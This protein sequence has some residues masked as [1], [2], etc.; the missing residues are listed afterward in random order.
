M[1]KLGCK[2]E[3]ISDWSGVYFVLKL[4]VMCVPTVMPEFGGVFIIHVF[5]LVLIMSVYF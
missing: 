1:I 4:D 5:L 3:N 2:F